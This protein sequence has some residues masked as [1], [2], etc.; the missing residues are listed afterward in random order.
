M[1]RSMPARERLIQATSHLIELQG[2]HATG[3]N[4][5][6]RGTQRVIVLLFS[7]WK[8]RISRR[9]G[10][11]SRASGNAQIQKALVHVTDPAEAV[12]AIITYVGKVTWSM[13]TKSIWLGR[14]LMPACLSKMIQCL[15]SGPNCNAHHCFAR[16][17]SRT[18]PDSSQ[19][20]TFISYCRR[21][22]A[23]D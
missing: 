12:H 21:N 8:R 14:M 7:E 9:I 18:L 20:G 4:Q 11:N 1:E 3:L 16:G 6:R 22:K 10:H 15:Q 5:R 19:P 17:G 13:Q 2:Y 23:V